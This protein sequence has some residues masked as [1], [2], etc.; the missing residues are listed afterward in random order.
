MAYP[1]GTLGVTLDA[2]DKLAIRTKQ[3][4]TREKARLAAGSVPSAVIFGIHAN[5]RDADNNVSCR[6]NLKC[7]ERSHIDPWRKT[8]AGTSVLLRSRSS[9]PVAQQRS[10]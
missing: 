4:A 3:I 10:A 2:I 1:T 5:M 6:R 9:S 7:L 8:I